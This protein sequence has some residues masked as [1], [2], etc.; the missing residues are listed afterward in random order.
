MEIIKL[1]IYNENNILFNQIIPRLNILEQVNNEKNYLGNNFK[2]KYIGLNTEELN[3]TDQDQKTL[4]YINQLIKENIYKLKIDEFE[5]INILHNENNKLIS[6]LL[7]ITNK[8]SIQ[9]TLSYY[10]EIDK[11]KILNTINIYN[12]L[13][14]VISIEQLNEYNNIFKNFMRSILVEHKIIKEMMT[15]IIEM[16]KEELIKIHGEEE[17]N[18]LHNEEI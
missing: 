6:D 8:S 18:R 13:N 17:G 14:M 3:N 15:D 7:E 12:G 5:I 11:D 9:E 1:S 16:R 10:M 4:E 2:N